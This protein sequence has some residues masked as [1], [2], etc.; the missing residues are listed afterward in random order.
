MT[1]KTARLL[2]NKPAWSRF[3]CASIAVPTSRKGTAAPLWCAT[4]IG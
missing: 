1:N 3:A 2:L 4:M